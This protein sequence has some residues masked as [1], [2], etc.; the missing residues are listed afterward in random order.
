MLYFFVC[1]HGYYGDMSES[2]YS[3]VPADTTDTPPASLRLISCNLQYGTPS[4]GW[5]KDSRTLSLRGFTPSIHQARTALVTAAQELKSLNPDILLLQE[6]DMYQARS[7]NLNQVKQVGEIL[8]MDYWEYA[9]IFSGHIVGLHHNPRSA[10]ARSKRGYGLA[11]FSRFP[12]QRSL[13]LSLPGYKSLPR[14]PITVDAR[15]TLLQRTATHARALAQDY[16]KRFKNQ[17][18]I[19]QGAVIDT[20]VGIVAIGNTHLETQSKVAKRQALLAWQALR[21]LEAD[22]YLLAGDFNVSPRTVAQSLSV[23]PEN[24]RPT[25]HYFAETFPADNPRH[26]LDQLLVSGLRTRAAVTTARLSISDHL[27]V[28]YDLTI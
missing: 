20:P 1:S 15:S 16:R 13:S 28:I 25:F 3:A 24:Q 7:G 4:T 26:P 6:V 18:R 14:E 19:V 5:D 2:P 17:A 27:A 10:W 12:I 8:D 23:L 9:P 11:L 22:A 21:D